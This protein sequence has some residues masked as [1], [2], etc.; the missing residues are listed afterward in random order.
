[1]IFLSPFCSTFFCN[2][3]ICSLVWR[4]RR[5]PYCRYCRHAFAPGRGGDSGN[6]TKVNQDSQHLHFSCRAPSASL[7][8]IGKYIPFLP[9]KNEVFKL[10]RHYFI[11]RF[12]NQKENYS[13][14]FKNSYREAIL[15]AD[16]Y[17]KISNLNFG[18]D[19][20]RP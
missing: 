18:M 3:F 13:I 2:Y 4:Y 14:S 11:L 8:F 9:P 5:A 15:D 1:M 16:I 20:K 10:K 7:S 19:Q 12:T 17:H 6:K